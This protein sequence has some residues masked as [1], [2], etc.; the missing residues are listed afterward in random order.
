MPA[1]LQTCRFPPSV[2]R[3]KLASTLPRPRSRLLP[4]RPS[5]AL[6]ALASFVPNLAQTTALQQPHPDT[7]ALAPRLACSARAACPHLPF[8]LAR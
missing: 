4:C 3:S 5:L 7:R 1:R 8:F 6:G 2:N